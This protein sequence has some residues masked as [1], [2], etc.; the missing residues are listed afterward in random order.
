M[1]TQQRLRELF[2]YSDG[3]L[4]WKVSRRGRF[5]KPGVVAGTTTGRYVQICVDMKHYAAHRLIWLLH[6]GEYPSEL[7]HIYQDKHDN[8]LEN[9]RECNRSQNTGNVGLR[10]TNTTGYRGIWFANHCGKWRA[11]IK[12]NG[13]SKH[14]GYFHDPES[15][16]IAYDKAAIEHFGEFAYLN[17]VE[18]C[19]M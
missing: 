1:I 18:K 14:L 15:A 12:I 11:A 7:D 17:E 2:D 13:K 16:A 10:S 5:I 3:K 9:L 19:A 8:R 6:Y 4:I